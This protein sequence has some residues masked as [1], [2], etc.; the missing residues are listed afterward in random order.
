MFV[1][2][3]CFSFLVRYF[4]FVGKCSIFFKVIFNVFLYFFYRFCKLIEFDRDDFLKYI[5]CFNCIVFY[6]YGDVV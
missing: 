6:R 5:V 2:R 4:F 3:N 1:L